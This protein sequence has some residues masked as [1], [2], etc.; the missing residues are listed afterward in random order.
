LRRNQWLTLLTPYQAERL[1]R[2]DVKI[3]TARPG[4]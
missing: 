2:N 4:H 3:D 1:Q